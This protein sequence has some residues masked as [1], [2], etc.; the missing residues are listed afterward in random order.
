MKKAFTITELLVAMTVIVII[1]AGSGYVFH[2]SVQAERVSRATAEISRKLRG[3]TD[4]LN[5]DFKGLRKDGEILA[6]WIPE[7]DPDLQRYVRFDRIMFFASGNFTSYNSPVEG[8]TARISYMLAKDGSGRRIQNQPPAKRRLARTQHIFTA[9][10]VLLS[11]APCPDLS[12]MPSSFTEIENNKYEYDTMTMT[13]WTTQPWAYKTDMITIVTDISRSGSIQSGGAKI[14]DSDPTSLQLLLCDG[15]GEFQIQGL[16]EDGVNPPRWVPE[17][18]PDND[19][20]GDLSDTDFVVDPVT[21]TL[22]DPLADAA[23]TLYP[24]DG[25]PELYGGQWIPKFQAIYPNSDVTEANF[26]SIP[27]L[28]RAFKF[29][30]TIYDSFE[31][32]PDGK[33]FTHI[34]YLD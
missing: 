26:N 31:I 8:N 6:M 2:T 28:G 34:I 10:P 24:Y 13:E 33:T 9:D 16:Y 3:I 32:Y 29:T 12:S 18:N 4:Q 19:I 30:F 27:G 7:Y 15:V 21:P 22:L 11:T 17:V 23:W 14:D 1:L 5:A 25:S 20:A